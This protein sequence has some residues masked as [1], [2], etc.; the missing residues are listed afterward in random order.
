MYYEVKIVFIIWLLSPAT[1]VGSIKY[2]YCP[3]TMESFINPLHLLHLLCYYH[4]IKGQ[5]PFFISNSHFLH[6]CIPTIITK[7]LIIIVM[8]IS[9]LWLFMIINWC[10]FIIHSSTMKHGV[11]FQGSWVPFFLH[12][13]RKFIDFFFLAGLKYI[14]QKICTSKIS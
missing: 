6:V 1:K 12:Y 3:S 2:F 10:F 5:A 8:I 14:V 13:Y 7:N 11:L 9:R 4:S